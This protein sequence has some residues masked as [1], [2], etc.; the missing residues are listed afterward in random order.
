MYAKSNGILRTSMIFLFEKSEAMD[1]K[2]SIVELYNNQFNDL[3]GSAG[4]LE[5]NCT[6]KN[7]CTNAQKRPISK[8]I[9][10]EEVLE[11]AMAKRVTKATNQNM[12]SSRSH[13]FVIIERANGKNQL[14]FADLAGFVRM[15]K[16][17]SVLMQHLLISTR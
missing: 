11:L 12:S 10:L 3:I 14:V 5:V 16:S 4:K 1:S 9:D 13:A 8:L 2:I 7:I 15:L 17:R 6:D